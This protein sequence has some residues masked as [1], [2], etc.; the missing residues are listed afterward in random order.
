MNEVRHTS[1]RNHL[2]EIDIEQMHSG[3]LFHHPKILVA[4]LHLTLSYISKSVCGLD[5]FWSSTTRF[6]FLPEIIIPF[7][8]LQTQ[9]PDSNGNRTD[10]DSNYSSRSNNLRCLIIISIPPNFLLPGWLLVTSFSIL[11]KTRSIIAKHNEK[12]LSFLILP[13]T[14]T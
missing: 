1:P 10:W 4:E 11:Y 14:H 12:I 2:N 7:V 13:R 8:I 3:A 9:K 6:Q 5:S